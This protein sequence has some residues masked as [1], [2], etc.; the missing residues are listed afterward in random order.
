MSRREVWT[1]ANERKRRMPSFEERRE[2]AE[3]GIVDDSL[4]TEAALDF[5]DWEILGEPSPHE[6]PAAEPRASA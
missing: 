6:R 2:M 3:R 1:M 4:A 5:E